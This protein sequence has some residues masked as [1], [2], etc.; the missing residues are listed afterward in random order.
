MHFQWKGII[1]C[2]IN[3]C[4]VLL[5]NLRVVRM[6][7]VNIQLRLLL[8]FSLRFNLPN[9]RLIVRPM[10][11]SWL[12]LR[13]QGQYREGGRK[14]TTASEWKVGG[15]GNGLRSSGGRDEAQSFPGPFHSIRWTRSPSYGTTEIRVDGFAEFCTRE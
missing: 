1:H 3:C 11:P 12:I 7:G 9:R 2:A 6:A 15:D 14:V 8:Q 13:L 5:V 10:E 4:E